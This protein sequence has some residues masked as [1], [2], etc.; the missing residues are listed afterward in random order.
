MNRK[1]HCIL[2]ILKISGANFF[3]FKWMPYLF[4]QIQTRYAFFS[5][6]RIKFGKKS[7]SHIILAST[8]DHL[9]AWDLLS[10]T[11]TAMKISTFSSQFYFAIFMCGDERRKLCRLTLFSPGMTY[12]SS[13]DTARG[14]MYSIFN[15]QFYGVQR[16]KFCPF[17][18][19]RAVM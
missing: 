9:I 18:L 17:F 1:G 11:G 5:Y 7:C 15:L 6:R 14:F 8:T 4:S 2:P 10:C 16:P 3:S 19:I 13:G 12:S